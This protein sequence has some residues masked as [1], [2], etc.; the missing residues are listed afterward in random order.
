MSNDAFTPLEKFALA[1]MEDMREHPG[2]DFDGGA[3]QDIAE[4]CGLI[5]E[6]QVD[7][8]CS[9]HYCECAEVSDFPVRCMRETEYLRPLLARY[10]KEDARG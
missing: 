8:P 4:H 5:K 1:I 10:R 2:D 3:L 6:V 9:D 7:A